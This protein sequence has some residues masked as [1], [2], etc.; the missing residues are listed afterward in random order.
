MINETST[1]LTHV[2]QTF[3]GTFGSFGMMTIICIGSI[4]PLFVRGMGLSKSI[5]FV[6]LIATVL[7][8]LGIVD[9]GNWI[10]C[11]WALAGIILIYNVIEHLS[12]HIPRPNTSQ[13]KGIFI[14]I[15]RLMG[16]VR[17]KSTTNEGVP[18]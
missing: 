6:T 11:V 7:Q 8:Y 15:L 9:M 14:Y 5:L 4:I 12:E 10:W 17:I 3:S 2:L 13:T 18:K 1:T 16:I